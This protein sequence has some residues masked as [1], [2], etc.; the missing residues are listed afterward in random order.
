MRTIARPLVR[1]V[2]RDD[3]G[4]IGVLVAVLIGG[5]VLLGMGALVIDV[6]QIYQ[7]RA[8]LQNGA[9]AAAM[10]AARQC[11]LGIF[12]TASAT[13]TALGYAGLNASALTQHTA[14][15]TAV[16]GS[17]GL[18]SCSSVVGTGLTNCPPD[19]ATGV[20]FVDVMT[21]TKLANG[22]TLLPPVF[23]KTLVGSSTYDGTT[24]KACA[25]AEW[26]PPS[27]ADTIAF[28][29]SGCEWDTATNNGQKYVAPYPP[30]PTDP[31]Y[32]QVLTL[33]SG[34][35]SGQCQANPADADAPG[36]FGWTDDQTGTC[37]VLITNNT[38][39]TNTGTSA[40]N[41]CKAALLTA[42]TSRSVVYVP[43]YAAVVNQGNN[44][45][46]TLK[47]FAAFVVT[48]YRVPSASKADWLNPGLLCGP[49]KDC[50]DGFFTNG[51][52]TQSPGGSGGTQNLGV[53][54]F[55]L[56]G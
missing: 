41:S 47:G 36:A 35:T 17:S 37:T 26:G 50:I 29:V 5:G 23:G 25:Q 55:K 54:S 21:S 14:G 13:S 18:G 44:T 39:N 19:P 24:V 27:G 3:R 33:H 42:W 31:S 11:A 48:G 20:N 22:S 34:Q 49:P 16:C 8:E 53:S 12:T 30:A 38:Y 56:T 52:L 1:L 9:D 6:G 46:Y 15:V 2:G 32:D 28:T 7:N 45:V 40:G 51:V 4:V 10:G 43:V